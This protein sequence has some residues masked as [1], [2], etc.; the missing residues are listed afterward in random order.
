MENPAIY[1]WMYLFV[2]ATVSFGLAS[3]DHIEKAEIWW[4]KSSDAIQHLKVY[5]KEGR[6]A[7]WPA[8]NGIWNWGDEI[9]VGFVEAEHQETE[10]FHTYNRETTRNKYARSL[11]GGDSWVIEDAYDLG[12]TGKSFDNNLSDDEAEEP[13][14]LEEPIEDFTNTDF[15]I[16]WMRYNYHNGPS[17]FYY[18]NDRGHQ[19]YGPHKFPDLDTHGIGTRTD[20][21]VNGPQQLSAFHN[22]A[23][24]NG[25]EGRVLH[26]RTT[27]GGVTWELVSWLGD[28]PEGFE[29]MP[30]TV[31]LSENE[32]YSVLRGREVDP[33]R[34]YLKAYRS[35]DNGESWTS[36]NDP[37]VDTG[38]NGSPPAM[39]QMED[40]RLALAYAYR[41][42]Y[43]SRICLRISD[44]KGQTW[45][46]EI[47]VR[48]GDGAN[49]D[50]GY[51]RMVQREDG[52]LV[53]V[54]YWNHAAQEDSS[55]Y[56]YIAAS[57]V[58]PQMYE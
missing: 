8:N 7:G 19:W 56:R 43:G 47:P 51:P 50:I 1:N 49:A 29:I 6:F 36:E 3:M 21:I 25:R 5:S 24:G 31:R 11:D 27:D 18:S 26:A 48:T 45:S 9:L 42:Q 34:D 4:G 41:S 17:I 52:N 35:T 13:T 12:Q 23:K 15:I 2:I 39:L 28:E 53:I 57:I 44:D 54:Y 40:G 22:A 32:L 20:Y 37:V 16:T 55:P 33:R 30:S 14:N 10:G 38:Y 46:H 58:N